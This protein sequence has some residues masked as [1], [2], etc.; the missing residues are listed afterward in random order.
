MRDLGDRRPVGEADAPGGETPRPNSR[1]VRPLQ[2][3]VDDTLLP[4]GEA[5]GVGGIGEHLLHRTVDLRA[6]DDRRHS[7]HLREQGRVPGQV[8]RPPGLVAHTLADGLPAWTVTVD[9]AVLQLQAGAFRG[10]GDEPDLDLAGP[11]RISLDLPLRAD[12]P[13]EDDPIRWLV[14]EDARPTALAAVNPAVVDVPTSTRLEDS[15]GDL[16]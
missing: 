4:L 2:V 6:G 15:L 3:A 13:A 12:V 8:Q 9:V 1:C 11:L 16:H 14:G 5:S 7:A 10:L